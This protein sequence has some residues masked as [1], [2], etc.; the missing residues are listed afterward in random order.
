MK[1][2]CCL[3]LN[4]NDAE[5]VLSLVDLIQDFSEIDEILVVDNK[6]SDHSFQRLH[7]ACAGR[8]HLV[9]TERNGGYGY[10]NNFG[11]KYAK[12]ELHCDYVLL[13]NPDVVFSDELV[14]KLKSTMSSHANC[15][16]VTAVQLDIND[17]PIQDFAW[18]IPTALEYAVSN[19][20]LA[21]LYSFR[22]Y[23]FEKASAQAEMEVECVPG[24]LLLY[25]ADKFL[26]VGGYDEEMFLFC[27]EVTIGIK[28]KKS[29]YTTIL[30]GTE[31]YK[32]E[33]S[34]SINK[35]IESERKKKSLMFN[36]RR[37]VMKKYMKASKLTIAVAERLQ[38]RS[39]NKLS[40]K[41]KT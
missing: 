26:E 19:T 8:F 2:C 1:R 9:S 36:N 23:S 38:Q 18:R 10:G 22:A 34:V 15:A 31:R 41:E 30:L 29:R 11:I 3:I 7:D 16:L 6:S 13:S 39:L 35:S 33:H 25:D 17:Q 40:E 28:L 32:H 4:Y 21:K 20:R 14:K 5:T 24:A 12:E 37:I 27:E